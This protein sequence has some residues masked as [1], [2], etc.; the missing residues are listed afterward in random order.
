[1]SASTLEYASANLKTEKKVAMRYQGSQKVYSNGLFFLTEKGMFY[2]RRVV[3]IFN[4]LEDIGGMEEAIALI[5]SP[6]V[7]AIA[8]R[9]FRY[10]LV[11]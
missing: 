9:S 1:M 3:T 10:D 7:I 6:F 2:K 4:V 11:T 8:R 5:M